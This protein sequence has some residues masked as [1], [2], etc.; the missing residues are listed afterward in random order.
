ML[1][2]ALSLGAGHLSP[3]PLDARHHEEFFLTATQT[4]S[5]IALLLRLRLGLGSAAALRG[6]F[7][8][9][10]VLAAVWQGNAA[11]TIMSLTWSRRG[12]LELALLFLAPNSNALVDHDK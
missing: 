11:R 7:V 9:Q 5:G 8:A 6:L 1:P 3:L 10:V 2:L 12:Y 4:L